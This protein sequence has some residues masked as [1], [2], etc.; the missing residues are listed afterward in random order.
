MNI[1][2]AENSARETVELKPETIKDLALWEIVDNVSRS[3]VEKKIIRDIFRKIP[4]DINDIRFRQDILKDLL[5]NE[6]LT[7]K[8]T[9]ILD[10]IKALKEFETMKMAILHQE[11]SLYVLLEKLRELSVY[12]NVTED[13]VNCLKKTQ[14]H[15]NGLKKI[16]FHLEGIVSDEWFDR[17][18]ADI[19]KMLDEL[20]NVRSAMVGVNFTADLNIEEVSV[21]E[22][23]PHRIKSKYKLAEIAASM[24]SIVNTGSSAN[25]AGTPQMA[26]RMLDPL[27][28]TMTP[29]IEKHM[30]RHY[31]KIKKVMAQHIRLDTS[32]VTELYE[33]LTFY[34]AMSRFAK[35]LRDGGCEICMPVLKDDYG[36]FKIKNLYNVRLFFAH[37]KNIV[38]ND[39][40]FTPKEN[41]YILTGPNRGGKTIIEQ[42]L[43][44]I[45]VM[46]SIGCFVTASYCEGRPFLNVLT[47]FP[48]DENLTINYGRLGEEA[49]RIREL[50]ADADDRTLI[51]FN[52]TYSTTSAAD[53]LYLSMDLLRVLKELGTAAIFNTHIHELAKAIDEM[54]EW[55]GE[56]EIVS[57]VMEIVNNVNTF[58]IKRSAPELKSYARNIAQKY[59]IT[60][61]QMMQNKRNV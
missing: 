16:L 40:S 59:E 28:V 25:S 53:G 26:V 5:G 30:K 45:S 2:F 9:G 48:V 23:L 15:S 33:G 13:I 14:L 4:V 46:T 39:F 18:K 10:Q 34:I 44:I 36:T 31:V 11:D 8:L 35:K 29:Q 54:N 49:V 60:Y 24:G 19:N 56:S 7:E 51:L 1:L 17:T 50:V 55:D 27:L 12:V 20:S 32:F 43:G 41:L 57:I 38:K 37:E 58:R 47:H 3:D 6:L 52:E 42:S 21:V 22:F 61:E